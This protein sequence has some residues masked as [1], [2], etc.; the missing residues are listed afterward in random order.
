[1]RA[2]LLI[3][4]K[5]LLQ[6]IR[7]RTV[8]IVALIAPLTLA[9]L[10]GLIVGGFGT[11]ALDAPRWGIINLDAGL[12]GQ[13]LAEQVLPSVAADF[14]GSL[15]AVADREVAE[16][17]I[18]GDALDAVFVI[19]R[20]LTELVAS[21]SPAQV[22]VLGRLGDALR[23]AVAS[24]VAEQ[25]AADLSATG[26]GY[27]IALATGALDD[28][29]PGTTQTLLPAPQ[30]VTFQDVVGSD[31]TLD[32]PTYVAA[33]MGIFFLFFTV[34]LGVIGLLEERTNGTLARLQVSPNPRWSMLLGKVL[35]SV[36]I[37]YAATVVLM[38]ASTF[39]L[40]ATWGPTFP[41]LVLIA[42]AVLAAVSLV[43]VVASF[44]ESADTANNIQGIV[45][46]ILGMLGGAFFPVATE[47]G[48]LATA[49]DLTPHG[50]F[51]TA[52]GDLQVPGAGLSQIAP[53]LLGLLAFALITTAAG[54]AIGRLREVS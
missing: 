3:L 22:V 32:G 26:A 31:R 10:L 24:S 50:M 34:G 47:P 1:M 51:L 45:G 29:A 49:S 25:W 41:V 43:T 2:A 30:L 39:L 48:L 36:V 7:D 54:G 40:D 13:S 35:T 5:D 8:W 46:I 17:R 52:I 16:T 28:R 38:I 6:R 18:E 20:N 53:Q 19:D 4:R 27:R 11:Q 44:A 21:G 12:V 23:N 9:G 37:G 42:A 33:G 14:N 15:V